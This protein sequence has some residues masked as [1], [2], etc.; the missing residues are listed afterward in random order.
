VDGAHY[1]VFA[2]VTP[3]LDSSGRLLGYH[4]NRR[5]PARDAVETVTSLYGRLRAEEQRHSRTPDAVAAGSALLHAVLEERG[6]TY[7]EFL[8]EIAG[9]GQ[10]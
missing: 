9:G 1:W 2:H 6:Q 10:R 7:D 3:S 8:W 4:S 5:A